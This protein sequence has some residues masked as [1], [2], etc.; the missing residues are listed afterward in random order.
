MVAHAK[1]LT[2]IKA[3]SYI[4]P[5]KDKT[6][7]KFYSIPARGSGAVTDSH[8]QDIRASVES[9]L[10]LAATIR[11]KKT[12]DLE[13]SDRVARRLAAYKKPKIDPAIEQELARYGA[14]RNN[15]ALG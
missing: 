7:A 4:K 14:E 9:A 10:A 3:N 8:F 13:A 11:S 5:K 12:L 2:M 15:K 6:M 1:I